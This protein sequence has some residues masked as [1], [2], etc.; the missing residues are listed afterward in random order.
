MTPLSLS[1]TCC[2]ADISLNLPW[3]Q[4][5]GLTYER[6]TTLFLKYLYATQSPSFISN[7]PRT[8]WMKSQDSLLVSI[9]KSHTLSIQELLDLTR[10]EVGHDLLPFF[11]STLS[12]FSIISNL[13]SSSETTS[14]LSRPLTQKCN[15]TQTQAPSLTGVSFYP[16]K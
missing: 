11:D 2:Q 7:C 3:I 6:F 14:N 13:L 8:F 4:I 15:P 10:V 16:E 5:H 12:L 9:W 1:C